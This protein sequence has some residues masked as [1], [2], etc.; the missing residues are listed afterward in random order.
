ME[1]IVT[2]RRP[3]MP[4]AIA[5]MTGRTRRVVRPVTAVNTASLMPAIY[6]PAKSITASLLRYRNQFITNAS[7]TKNARTP[8]TLKST[9]LDC[10][11][12]HHDIDAGGAHF[13][14][15]DA[16]VLSQTDI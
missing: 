11:R 1:Y 14:A 9:S 8:F 5:S 12:G 13:A 3:E 10:Q 15:F 16:I 6:T 2:S 4:I 7:T